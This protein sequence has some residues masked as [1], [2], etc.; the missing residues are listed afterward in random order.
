MHYPTVK[1]IKDLL[2]EEKAVV[3]KLRAILDSQTNELALIRKD[4]TKVS[5]H[6]LKLWQ[7]IKTAKGGQP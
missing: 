5:T 4:G 2:P 6:P 7:P 3:D 1:D